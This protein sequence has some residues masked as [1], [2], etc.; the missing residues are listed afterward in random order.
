MGFDKRIGSKFLHAGPGFGGS[1][2]PKDVKAF[3]ATAK[4]FNTKL[5]IIDA[6]NSS[7]QKRPIKIASNISKFYND[8]LKNIN[9]I[10]NY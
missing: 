7:N 3:S 4:K 8:K 6:V 1:C 5:S 9:K 10:F 2:F